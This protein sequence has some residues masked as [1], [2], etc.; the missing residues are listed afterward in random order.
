MNK[1]EK[2]LIDI[3]KKKEAYERELSGLNPIRIFKKMELNRLFSEAYKEQ[4]D[5]ENDFNIYISILKSKD[6]KNAAM[7]NEI[8]MLNDLI[9]EM[10]KSKGTLDEAK[11]VSHKLGKIFRVLESQT[12]K[13]TEQREEVII[14]KREIET[15]EEKEENQQVILKNFY[16]LQEVNEIEEKRAEEK[17]VLDLVPDDK[18]IQDKDK[19]TAELK[20]NLEAKINDAIAESEEEAE[21]LTEA[22]NIKLENREYIKWLREKVSDETV[23]Q[24]IENYFYSAIEDKKYSDYKKVEGS[25]LSRDRK[26]NDIIKILGKTISGQEVKDEDLFDLFSSFVKHSQMSIEKLKVNNSE[27]TFDKLEGCNGFHLLKVAGIVD[28]NN[29][30]SILD[31]YKALSLEEILGQ[32]VQRAKEIYFEVRSLTDQ[33]TTTAERSKELVAPMN[34]FMNDFL[35]EGEITQQYRNISVEANLDDYK[36]KLDELEEANNSILPEYDEMFIEEA[37]KGIEK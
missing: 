19:V 14:P 35:S 8:L 21:V 5:K 15:F 27:I 17:R 6:K 13:A 37:E 24:V 26:Y 9:E 22:Y 34:S 36:K 32:E 30:E 20:G 1:I 29:V 7:S 11:A 28:E 25:I 18:E 31:S 4:D 10:G 23:L 12:I 2:E 16:D 33:I 3:V